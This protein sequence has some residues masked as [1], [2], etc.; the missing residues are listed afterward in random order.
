[1][2]TDN[3]R[4]GSL[5]NGD[6]HDDAV[7]LDSQFSNTVDLTMVPDY[8]YVGVAGDLKVDLKTQTGITYK[9]LSVGFHPIRP[10]RI[11]A[12]G[13]AATDVLGCY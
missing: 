9:N 5:E 7:K 13:T 4:T 2:A 12:T 6:P 11:Y 3:R 1:M 8:I 10:R